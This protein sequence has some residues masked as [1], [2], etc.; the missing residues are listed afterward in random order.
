MRGIIGLSLLTMA[1]LV[2]GGALIAVRT[3]FTTWATNAAASNVVTLAAIFLSAEGFGLVGE[4][5]INQGSVGVGQR[6]LFYVMALL[7]VLALYGMRKAVKR[8]P[9][10]AELEQQSVTAPSGTWEDYG[11]RQPVSVARVM[12]FPEKAIGPETPAPIIPPQKPSSKK[13]AA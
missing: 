6:V 11:R 5:L 10:P 13:R 12:P 2:F 7:P 8:L 3:R 4:F 9:L 1:V